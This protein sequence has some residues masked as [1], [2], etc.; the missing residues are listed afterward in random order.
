MSPSDID[1]RAHAAMRRR[2]QTAA[3]AALPLTGWP[4]IDS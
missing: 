3:K 1:F 2:S 4:V